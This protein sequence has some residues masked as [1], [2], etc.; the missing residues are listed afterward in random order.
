MSS[1][2]TTE[3]LL[4]NAL[5]ASV[6]TRQ[7]ALVHHVFFWLKRP[8]VTADRDRLIEGI[9]TLA[10]IETVRALHVGVPASTVE[11][12]VVDASYS[13]SEL[14]VFDDVV[15]QN[16]YQA[17]PLHAKFVADCSDLWDRVVVYDTMGL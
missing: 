4:A 5:G 3:P 10:K 1:P 14:L 8:S 6:P 2:T 17:H 7:A 13:V 9:R 16:L 11:R 12:P 15:G